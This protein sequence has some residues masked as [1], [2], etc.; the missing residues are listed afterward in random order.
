MKRSQ[1]SVHTFR[2]NEVER[3]KIEKAKGSLSIGE[4]ARR[5][6]LKIEF[7]DRRPEQIALGKTIRA[8]HLA[9][10]AGLPADAQDAVRSLL[11]EALMGLD[12]RAPDERVS[13]PAQTWGER[14]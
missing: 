5:A 9:I 2:L 8:I 12:K 13:T 6:A 10:A 11:S 14:R 3:A 4:F 7:S 1:S